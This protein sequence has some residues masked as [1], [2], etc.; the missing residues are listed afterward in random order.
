MPDILLAFVGKPSAGKSS[1]LNAVTDAQAKVGNFPFTTIKPNHGVSYIPVDCPCKR[2]G[3]QAQCSPRYG[4]CIDGTRYLPIKILDVAG[5]V[6]G[7]SE[8]QGLGNQFLDDLRTADA[9]IHVVDVSGTTDQNGKETAGYDPINDINWLRSEIHNWVF[10][11]LH[12]R[13]GSIVRRHVAIKAL[14]AETLQNQFSGY[15]STVSLCHRF[16]EKCGIKEAL[17]TWDD[18]TLH[19]IVDAFLDERFPTVIALNKIDLPD[20]D[21]NIDRICRKYDESRI[22]LTSALAE[23]FLRKLHKQKFIKYFEGTDSFELAEDQ[24]DPSEEEKLKPLD[25]KTRSR[26][27]KVQD[28]VLFRYG[29]TG[30]LEAVKKAVDLLGMIPVYPVKNINN[31]SSFGRDNRVFRDCLLVPP[32]TTVRDLAKMVHPDLDKYYLYAETIGSIRLGEDQIITPEIS[33]ISFKTSQ[34]IGSSSNK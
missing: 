27:E 3:K 7:A 6:P 34:N 11:N 5:L 19:A 14:P 17:E 24:I 4:K 20:S 16:M 30:V 32:E 21:K 2:F 33:V 25:E 1:F 8:G 29:H 18:D 31:F 10:N 13:W 12:K 23:V 28:M 9:L 26:L 22:V 15:G